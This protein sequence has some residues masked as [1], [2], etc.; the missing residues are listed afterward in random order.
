MDKLGPVMATSCTDKGQPQP[1]SRGNQSRV[2]SHTMWEWA[3][4]RKGSGFFVDQVFLIPFWVTVVPQEVLQGP[5]K[6]KQ[7]AFLSFPELLCKD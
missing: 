5:P 1:V 4:A 6:Q 2:V 3:L 7:E